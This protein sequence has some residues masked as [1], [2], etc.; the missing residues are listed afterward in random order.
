MKCKKCGAE[1][2][3][4]FCSNCGEQIQNLE[5][6]FHQKKENFNKPFYKKWW[7]IFGI[8]VISIAIV[9]GMI[10]LTK[11]RKTQNKFNDSSSING[12]IETNNNVEGINNEVI[13]NIKEIKT[14]EEL[15]KIVLA[16]VE[17]VINN[18]NEEKNQLIAD[19]NSYEK[20][21]DNIDK[22]EDFYNK[23][24]ITTQNLGIKMREYSVIYAEFIIASDRTN[25]EKYEDLDQIY[26]VIYDE[27]SEQIY[28][29]I[30]DDLLED[31]YDSFYDGVIDD[32]YDTIP[33]RE[34]SDAGSKAYRMWSDT[35]SDVYREWSDAGSD[36]YRFWSDVSSEVYGEDIEGANEEIKDFKADIEKIKNKNNQIGENTTLTTESKPVDN[37][38]KT[39]EEN[40]TSNLVNGMRPEFK[41]AMDSYESFMNEYCEFMK[42]Y[43]N[44]NGSDYT[45]IADYSTY[46]SK[47][48]QFISE[49]EKWDTDEEMNNAETSYYIEV[50]ARVSKKLLEVSQ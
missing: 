6:E 44:S 4:E 31:M 50:Q 12:T 16:D 49:F 22:I 38:E 45:L 25:D 34:W 9:V 13:S 39:N 21:C 33:Y 46:M 1:L 47:Y 14:L 10:F 23:V 18:L 32:A 26:D 11:D 42:K 28:D 30:Y 19:I 36:V 8:I 24:L 17:N 27:F 15:E 7:F 29:E 5:N 2:K 3:G 20:Y 35:G 40:T 48:S 37:Q 43:I 41:E